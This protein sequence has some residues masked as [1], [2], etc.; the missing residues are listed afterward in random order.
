MP[1]QCPTGLKLCFPEVPGS[2]FDITVPY[3]INT[4]AYSDI[5]LN[6]YVIGVLLSYHI[7]ILFH[8]NVPLYQYPTVTLQ[9]NIV[10]LK[11]PLVAQQCII[12]TSD[13][14][15]F[16]T[17]P[18]CVI[19]VN[20]G[21]TVHYYNSTVPAGVLTQLKGLISFPIMTSQCS[22]MTFKCPIE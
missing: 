3:Y 10:T 18:Y 1:I 11:Y 20:K 7:F 12:V 4:L 22:Y 8:Y 17:V 21:T 9:S 15:V 5:V 6:Y 2:Y 14:V 16:I 19:L 13:C